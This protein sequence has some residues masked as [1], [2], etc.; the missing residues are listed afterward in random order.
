MYTITVPITLGHQGE[1][2]SELQ[3]EMY[4]YILLIMLPDQGEP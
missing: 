2:F 4:Q 1:R 3:A